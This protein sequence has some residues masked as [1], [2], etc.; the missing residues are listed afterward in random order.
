MVNGYELGKL[1]ELVARL[2]GEKAVVF[3]LRACF[4]DSAYLTGLVKPLGG[5]GR[6]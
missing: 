6:S 2:G 5:A 1:P 4:M 3:H